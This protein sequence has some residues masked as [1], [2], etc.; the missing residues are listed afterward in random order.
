MSLSLLCYYRHNFCFV[1]SLPTLQESAVAVKHY[2]LNTYQQLVQHL[3]TELSIFQTRIGLVAGPVHL[4]AFPDTS[5][6]VT[7]TKRATQEVC[8]LAQQGCPTQ[9]IWVW[10]PDF[11]DIWHLVFFFLL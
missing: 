8:E 4:D 5:K 6:V 2:L 1:V 7:H 10:G 9:V 11:P 3:H